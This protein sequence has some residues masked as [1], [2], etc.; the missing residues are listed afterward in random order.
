M[1]KEKKTKKK[2]QKQKKKQNT[3]KNTTRKK[4]KGGMKQTF[5]FFLFLGCWP[6]S[7]QN[8]A[9]DKGQTTI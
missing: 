8:P 3:K 9:R 6:L 7:G 5:S 2:K 1:R 4:N